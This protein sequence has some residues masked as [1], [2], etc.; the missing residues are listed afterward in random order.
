MK[1]NL[2]AYL[3]ALLAM[4]VLDGFWIGFA[5]RGFYQG[6]IGHLMADAPYVPAAALFYLVYPLGL[7]L[8]VIIPMTGA[9]TQQAL[10]RGAL[11]GFFAYATYDLS[12]W[13]TLKEWP[14]SVAVVDMLWG[15][16]ASACATASARFAWERFVAH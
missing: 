15:A 3:A 4:L 14:A 10:L 12:N 5:A 1:E 8:F 9:T 2:A 13:A 6:G 16:F 11:F 7:M